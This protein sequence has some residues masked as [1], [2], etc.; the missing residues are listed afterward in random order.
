MTEKIEATL[1]RL[2][3]DTSRANSPTPPAR[4]QGGPTAGDGA[5]PDESLGR[6]D[7][8][9]CGG[10]GYVR[11]ERPVGD[12]DFGRLE[13]CSCR[14]AQ[15]RAHIRQRLFSLSRLD[16]LQHLTFSTF[17]SRGR[18]GIGDKQQESLQAAF[19]ACRDYARRLD[20][21]LLLTGTF[22]SG[23]T[24]LAA[25]IA[26]E[27]V[28]IGV[29][30][31]FL[32]VPDLLDTLR[33]SFD[34]EDTS[35]E[36]AFER[37]RS[38]PLLILDDF[39]THNATEWAR[40]KLFQILNHRYIN[41]LPLVVTMNLPLEEV[42]GRIRSRLSDQALVRAVHL[43]AP[44]YRRADTDRGQ[45]E[46]SSLSIH[47]HQT[48]GTWS[49]RSEEKLVP[50]DRRTLEEAFRTAHGYAEKPEGWLLL[51]G[52]YGSG[53]THLAAAIA[54]YRESQGYSV[55]FVVV[56]DL[57]DHLRATFSP[58]STVTYD[59]RFEQ[60]RTAPLLVLDD[61]GTQATTPWVLEK[62]HQVFNYRYNAALPTVITTADDE[63][64][65]DP[66]LLSRLKD[67]RL[68]T[69]QQITA[70][71]FRGGRARSRRETKRSG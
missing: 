4:D 47:A 63:K 13:I 18:P 45:P 32:T 51:Q 48:F 64:R 65:I 17:R 19:D 71:S 5:P 38:A 3:A 53:K 1:R 16:Q 62:L 67:R 29:P 60:V 14:Q 68:V 43:Q 46:L 8:P 49:Q 33:A 57:L 11:V 61:L 20:G 56:P 41:R 9:I 54:N 50:Q 36:E 24:H 2:A 35:F 6:P 70:P 59:Q 23:K 15:V 66:K 58:E 21:W 69:V 10:S 27:A 52:P 12:P 26:N 22:G 40:E 31:L 34:A 7:C 39:G 28:E 30:T 55:M 42:E 44:D 25:A 37:V